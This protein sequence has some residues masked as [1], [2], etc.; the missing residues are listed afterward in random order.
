MAQSFQICL[1]H[2]HLNFANYQSILLYEY[3]PIQ[4]LMPTLL[5]ADT[6]LKFPNRISRFERKIQ[7]TVHENAAVCDT[8]INF[9]ENTVKTA[10]HRHIQKKFY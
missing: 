5:V 8:K 4:Q 9:N 3:L 7:H 2:F 1:F 10:D 6:L